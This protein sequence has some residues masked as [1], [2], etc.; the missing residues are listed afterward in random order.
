MS[1]TWGTDQL[2]CAL[3]SPT[4]LVAGA[5]HA[6]RRGPSESRSTALSAPPPHTAGIEADDAVV[7]HQAERPT[8]GR[9]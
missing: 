8:S 3:K 4:N 6:N 7:A 1:V 9:R 2:A 5:R